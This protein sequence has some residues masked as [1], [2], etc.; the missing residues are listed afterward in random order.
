MAEQSACLAPNQNNHGFDYQY[1]YKFKS[2]L[3]LKQGPSSNVKTTVYLLDWQIA[4]LIEKFGI[5]R[6][7]G[8]QC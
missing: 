5:N 8:T 1:F 2:G 4:D 7:D 6:V 3:G